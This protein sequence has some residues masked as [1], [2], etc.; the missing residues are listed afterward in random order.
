MSGCNKKRA[1]LSLIESIVAIAVLVIIMA[2]ALDIFDRGFSAT[3]KTRERTV[4]YGLARELLEENTNWDALT[5]LDANP[6]TGAKNGP[7]NG[8]YTYPTNLTLNGV[9]YV[10]RIDVADGPLP[11]LPYTDEL[12]QLTATISWGTNSFSL[13]TLKA[14]FS[15]YKP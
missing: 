3:V 8:N 14:N 9:T 15:D 1:G 6:W 13:M 10:R 12:K 4:A 7:E 11:G 2:G 5:E